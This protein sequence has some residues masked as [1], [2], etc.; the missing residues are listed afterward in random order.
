MIFWRFCISRTTPCQE[1]HSCKVAKARQPPHAS[2][3]T[4]ARAAQSEQRWMLQSL[5]VSVNVVL[6]QQIVEVVA[7]E[8]SFV[9]YLSKLSGCVTSACNFQLNQ[10]SFLHQQQTGRRDASDKFVSC[11]N[12]GSQHRCSAT[13]PG[14][15][16]TKP[17]C[18]RDAPLWVFSP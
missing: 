16:G 11:G 14:E 4:L 7:A 15:K 5:N 12:A 8:S 9:F 18:L 1:G 10:P 2:A 17:P 3:P 6:A 13:H